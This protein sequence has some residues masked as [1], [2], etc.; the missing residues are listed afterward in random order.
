[1]KKLLVAAIAAAAVH[2]T[3]AWAQSSPFNWTGFYVGAE[4]GGGWGMVGVNGIPN[5]AKV[6]GYLGGVQAGAN[7]Q[8]GNSVVGVA[9][10]FNLSHLHGSVNWGGDIYSATV[11]SF[12]T[13]EGRLGFVPT[14]GSQLYASAG[15][16][17][18]EV[19]GEL[20]TFKDKKWMNG[21]TVGFGYEWMING[22]TSLFV[23]YKHVDF[24]TKIFVLDD[25]EEVHVRFD[26]VKAGVNM[27][28][29]S[30]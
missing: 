20:E 22:A 21:W 9:A 7:W 2:A 12:G 29:G 5:D 13:V 24:G 27:R 3:P 11:R 4:G 28:F 30:R 18:G 19:R 17:F 14:P 1:M 16:A 6:S 10:D 23:Q 8:N 15:F 25:P 26:V